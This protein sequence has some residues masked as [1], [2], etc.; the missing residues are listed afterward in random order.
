MSR[1]PIPAKLISSDD[2]PAL[3]NGSGSPFVGIRPSTTLMFTSACTATIVV[4]PSARSA[5]NASGARSAMR[6]PRHATTEKQT[7]TAV[8]PTSPSS[9]EMTEKMKSVCGS[10][11]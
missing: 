5:P 3:T 6:I 11:R 1:I 7:T 2:P 4:S 8:A 9:S 10:G